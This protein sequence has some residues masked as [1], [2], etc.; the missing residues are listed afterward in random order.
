[1]AEEWK[2]SEGRNEREMKWKL[3]QIYS[4]LTYIVLANKFSYGKYAIE[5][6]NFFYR[7]CIIFNVGKLFKNLVKVFSV[8]KSSKFN[9][10]LS[11]VK[12]KVKFHSNSVNTSQNTTNAGDTLTK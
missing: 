10:G 3:L 2:K 1:M 4:G 12:N 8:Y 5:V 9:Q 11:A 6:T 7:N